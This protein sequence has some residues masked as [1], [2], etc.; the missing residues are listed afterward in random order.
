MYRMRTVLI[1]LGLALLAVAPLG[2]QEATLAS[3]ADAA[4]LNAA[5][6]QLFGADTMRIAL[7]FALF[8]GQGGEEALALLDLQLT[9]AI[10]LDTANEVGSASLS[11][12]L[13]GVAQDIQA[14]LAG[15]TLYLDAGNGWSGTSLAGL[16]GSTA[17][18]G[19]DADAATPALPAL[20]LTDHGELWRLADEGGMI[21]LQSTL[22]L[23]SLAADPGLGALV[24]AVVTDD[25]AST[26]GMT[27]EELTAL[28]PLLAFIIQEPRV[29]TTYRIDP[30]SGQLTAVSADIG[31]AIN[32][33]ALGAAGAPITIVLQ[34]DLGF[35]QDV[36]VSIGEI[37]TDVPIAPFD[38][39]SLLPGGQA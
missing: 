20:N 39:D 28:L 33:A 25:I 11:L 17:A 22:D 15:D 19:A 37:P 5:A 14:I 8:I 16:L 31:G 13:G 18:D 30:G 9:G 23:L 34:L 2:A 7:D 4:R 26:A 29:E 10:T 12:L 1:L 38:F 32:P 27:G 21:Q 24:G 35:E 36:P 3:D 6:E